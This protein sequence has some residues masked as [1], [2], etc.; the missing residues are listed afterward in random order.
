[1][2]P[3]NRSGAH[4]ACIGRRRSTTAG[5]DTCGTPARASPQSPNRSFRANVPRPSVRVYGMVSWG[6]DF[7]AFPLL[8]NGRRR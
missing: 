2:K 7:I 3:T 1:M 8:M 4:D 5:C 6:P